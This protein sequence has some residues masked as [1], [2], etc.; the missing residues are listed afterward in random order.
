MSGYELFPSIL[1]EDDTYS[2]QDLSDWEYKTL[3]AIVSNLPTK[4]VNGKSTRLEMAAFL[5]GRFN[6]TTLDKMKSEAETDDPDFSE[7][8][9]A[10]SNINSYV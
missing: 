4:K 5:S 6:K 7:I 1:P 3:R 9:N 10:A 2:V 8:I